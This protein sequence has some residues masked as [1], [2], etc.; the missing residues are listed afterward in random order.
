MSRDQVNDL[1][2]PNNNTPTQVEAR[3]INTTGLRPIRSESDP[4]GTP[5]IL[6]RQ[7]S[8]FILTA[9]LLS[10]LPDTN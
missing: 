10:F 4:H 8:F 9:S 2:N 1:D 6:S 7:L 3:P 5:S